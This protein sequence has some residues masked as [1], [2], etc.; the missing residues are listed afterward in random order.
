VRAAVVSIIGNDQT[1]LGH[2]EIFRILDSVRLVFGSIPNH[3]YQIEHCATLAPPR[4]ASAHQQRP[5]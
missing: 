4:L 2:L 5:Q 3:Y 1:T